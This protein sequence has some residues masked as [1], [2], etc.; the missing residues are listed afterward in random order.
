[1]EETKVSDLAEEIAQKE[2]EMPRDDRILADT[3]TSAYI[4][5]WNAASAAI[6]A[7]QE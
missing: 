1:M 6:R 7:Q 3:A 2:S 5:G 4:D